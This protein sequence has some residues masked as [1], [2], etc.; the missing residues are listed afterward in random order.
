MGAGCM[1]CRE[2]PPKFPKNKKVKDDAVTAVWA[3]ECTSLE[4]MQEFARRMGIS[5]NKNEQALCDV[6]EEQV[7]VSA[8]MQRSA[9]S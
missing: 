4:E 6:L 1:A 7:R 5:R 9:C 2:Q 8:C 3:T